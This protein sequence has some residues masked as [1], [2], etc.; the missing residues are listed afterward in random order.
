[1][2]LSLCGVLV[3][4]VISGFEKKTCKDDRRFES[5][6]YPPGTV[7]LEIEAFE[8]STRFEEELEEDFLKA[9]LLR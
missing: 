7:R 1:M 3:Q 5:E 8:R 6:V 2:L 9:K 4:S